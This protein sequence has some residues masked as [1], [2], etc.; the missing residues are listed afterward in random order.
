MGSINFLHDSLLSSR[1]LVLWLNSD[2]THQG[3]GSCWKLHTVKALSFPCFGSK[4]A[5]GWHEIERGHS[6]EG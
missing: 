2:E 3:F 4:K 5:R 1:V 6:W